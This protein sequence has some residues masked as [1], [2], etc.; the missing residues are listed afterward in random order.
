MKKDKK[1][2]RAFSKTLLIQESILI[3][4]I[5][6]VFLVLAFICIMNG[7]TGELPWLTV[8]VSFPWG[9]YGISQA[10]YY[11]KSMKENSSGGIVYDSAFK[12]TPTKD[13]VIIIEEESEP[14]N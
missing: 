8:I 3:W 7:F 11:K 2:K 5:S 6:I 4:I 12:N 13:E 14:K 10:Y 9:A 1:E